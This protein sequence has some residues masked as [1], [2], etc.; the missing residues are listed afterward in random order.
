MKTILYFYLICFISTGLLSQGQFDEQ[1][2]TSFHPDSADIKYKI[3]MSLPKKAYKKY[4]PVIARFDV[5]NNDS[6]IFDIYNLFNPDLQE[7][8]VKLID[9][10]GNQFDRNEVIANPLV[11]R[12]L[13]YKVLPGDTLSLSIPINNWGKKNKN[14][15]IADN[16]W[17]FDQYG[18]FEPGRK[19]IAHFYNFNDYGCELI[20][21]DVE[22]EVIDLNDSDNQLLES[23]KE[24][25]KNYKYNTLEKLIFNYPENTF[26]EYISAIYLLNK[27]WMVQWANEYTPND[28]RTD[29]E[30]FFDHYPNSMYLLNHSFLS[31]YFKK[32]NLDKVTKEE[33]YERIKND[34]V[35]SVI[36]WFLK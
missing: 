8:H 3:N 27:Y 26:T 6:K 2:Y 31:S 20:S 5:I 19:Y 14:S 30:K 29:Y 1:S 4:E 11:V 16:D 18:Y 32:L 23:Y 22:F 15:T 25:T 28:V 36:K 33:A 10:L 34:K 21:N 17:F 13:H 12:K 35:K 7:A 24:E 9:D